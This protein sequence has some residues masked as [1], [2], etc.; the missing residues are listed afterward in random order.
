MA[1]YG[2]I[3][4]NEN[5]NYELL[6]PDITF[7]S[8]APAAVRGYLGTADEPDG[9]VRILQR[10]HLAEDTTVESV[11]I[12]K[13][14]RFWA[15]FSENGTHSLHELSDLI[16]TQNAKIKKYQRLGPRNCAALLCM[17]MGGI[18]MLFAFCPVRCKWVGKTEQDW[19]QA[20]RELESDIEMSWALQHINPSK[21]KKYCL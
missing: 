17:E 3:T 6:K 9:K 7:H 14:F 19:I 16:I 2:Y 13:A 4:K 21:L 12:R 8:T 20:Y 1:F 5:Y 11:E 15:G 18:E 10:A